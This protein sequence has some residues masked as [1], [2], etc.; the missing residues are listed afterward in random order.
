MRRAAALAA[1]ALCQLVLAGCSVS[2]EGSAPA[3]TAGTERLARADASTDHVV[4]GYEA[5][6]T[7]AQNW[8][9]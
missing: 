5:R 4:P 3:A 9:A 7:D 8:S 6:R 1:S 2:S